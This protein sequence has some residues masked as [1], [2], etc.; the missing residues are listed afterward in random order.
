MIIFKI[1]IRGYREIFQLL[2]F[3]C[4][5]MGRK[6]V[7]YYLFNGQLIIIKMFDKY[8]FYSLS[9]SENAELC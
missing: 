5:K 9:R 1:L 6:E 2:I 3:L 7:N 8:L 4:I